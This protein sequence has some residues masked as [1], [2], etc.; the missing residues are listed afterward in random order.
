MKSPLFTTISLVICTSVALGEQPAQPN[1]HL[2]GLSPFIGSWRFEGPSPEEV[3]GFVEKGSRC[4]VQFSWRWILDKQAVIQD[5]VGEFNGNKR[6]SQKELIGWDAKDAR[7]VS[8]GMNSLGVVQL[9]TITLDP[10]AKT[11]TVVT[12]GINAEGGRM[13]GK[14]VFTKVDSNTITFERLEITGSIVKGASPVYTL[15]RVQR[16][17]T[18]TGMPDKV[19]KALEFMCGSWETVSESG[20]SAGETELD[21]RKWSPGRHNLII[22]WA[23]T[24]YGEKVHASGICG[25]NQTTNELI[26]T[27]YVSNGTWNEVRYPIDEMENDVW[28][29]KVSWL[30]PDGT[31]ISGTCKLTPGMDQFGWT[32]QWKQDGEQKSLELLSRKVRN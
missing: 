31:R 14:A 21:E 4:T 20:E 8:G 24:L 28:N 9:S 30:E 11:L 5:L 6:V 17:G 16:R 29:G 26:E 19:L 2:K 32:C 7:L 12:E 3:P 13:A 23:G 22:T 27:W 15:K 18:P 1:E 25:W 10:Q